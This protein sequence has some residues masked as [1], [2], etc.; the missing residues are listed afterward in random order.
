MGCYKTQE[1]LYF[2]MNKVI[3]HRENGKLPR[4]NT[5]LPQENVKIPRENVKL[6][7][8]IAIFPRKNLNFPD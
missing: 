4:E 5:I 7:L 6:P 1:N 8:G 2:L 3:F